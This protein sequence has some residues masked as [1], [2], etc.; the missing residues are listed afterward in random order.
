MS[1]TTDNASH[2]RG[3]FIYIT[4]HPSKTNSGYHCT[5]CHYVTSFD[6]NC[7]DY[8]N[9]TITVV[10]ISVCEHLTEERQNVSCL[11]KSKY[12]IQFIKIHVIHYF[13]TDSTHYMDHCQSCWWI[14]SVYVHN[15]SYFI[16]LLLYL[17]REQI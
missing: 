3:Y 8:V 13:S 4:P 1:L 16:V 12:V 11:P 17:K 10:L 9:Y 7:L 15:C 2:F 6:V 14:S 5:T